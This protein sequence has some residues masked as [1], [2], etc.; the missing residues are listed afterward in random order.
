MYDEIFLI[1]ENELAEE[2]DDIEELPHFDEIEERK[3]IQFSD[4]VEPQS[5]KKKTQAEK[6][7]DI[8]AYVILAMVFIILETT[9]I[10]YTLWQFNT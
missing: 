2:W 7:E 6:I 8:L 9:L 4:K 1:D 5:E 10:G 3:E